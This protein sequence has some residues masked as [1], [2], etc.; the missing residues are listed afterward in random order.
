[1]FGGEKSIILLL[2]LFVERAVT[3]ECKCVCDGVSDGVCERVREM[4]FT[5]PFFPG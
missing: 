3:D 4:Y 2:S 1:M 5:A